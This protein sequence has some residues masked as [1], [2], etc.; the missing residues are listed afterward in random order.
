MHIYINYWNNPLFVCLDRVEHTDHVT[1]WK[2][3]FFASFLKSKATGIGGE[4]A[5]VWGGRYRKCVPAQHK[6]K[7]FK[8]PETIQFNEDSATN[9]HV[10][11]KSK[12]MSER[13]DRKKWEWNRM[14]TYCW[15]QV[16]RRSIRSRPEWSL[17]EPS[18]MGRGGQCCI[19]AVMWPTPQHPAIRS[20]PLLVSIK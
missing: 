18:V 12:I 4:D 3:Y 10:R 5:S 20:L 13:A 14:R 19:A 6:G 17:R 8:I 2:G 9:L 7:Y 1:K 16:V 15:R 11:W